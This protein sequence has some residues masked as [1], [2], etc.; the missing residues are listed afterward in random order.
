LDAACQRE[1]KDDITF[2]IYQ[3]GSANDPSLGAVAGPYQT[4]ETRDYGTAPE[5]EIRVH[6]EAFGDRRGADPARV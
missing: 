5:R 3:D 6:G 4:S 1:L 2:C